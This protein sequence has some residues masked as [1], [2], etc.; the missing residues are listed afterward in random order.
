MY[1]AKDKNVKTCSLFPAVTIVITSAH[2]HIH[3]HTHVHT[4]THICTHAIACCT[5]DRHLIS[6]QHLL[7]AYPRYCIVY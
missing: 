3:I 5:K 4:R 1:G 2:V 7:G 6:M